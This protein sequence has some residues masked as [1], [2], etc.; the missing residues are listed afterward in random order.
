MTTVSTGSLTLTDLNDSKQLILYLNGNYK[1]QIY[2]PN[3]TTYVPS[4]SSSNLVITPEL[5]IAGGNGTN[6]LPTSAVKSVTWY[7]G[8]QT[9]TALT[10]TT[11]GTTGGGLSYSIPTGAVATTAKPLTIKS[12][13]T[14]VNSQIFTCQVIYT[15]PATTFDITCKAQFEITKITNGQKGDAGIN[16]ITA[17]LSN[18]ADTVPADSSGGSQVIT[19]VSATIT[20]YEGATDVTSSWSMG[21]PVVTGLGALNTAYTLTGTPANRTFTLT[22]TNPMTADIAT[23]TWTLTRSGYASII[24][25]FTISRLKNG[26]AGTSPTLYRLVPS[27]NA[28]QRS[29]TNVFNPTSISFTSKSQ[30]GTGAYG[31]YNARWVIEDTTDNSTWTARTVNPTTDEATKSYTPSSTS[32]K[33]VRAKIYLAGG[34]TTLLD[35]QL[36]P[37]VFDGATGIDSLYLNVWAPNGDTMRNGSTNLD[38]Q[39]DLY[40]GAGLVTPTATKWYIQDGTAT[41]ASGGDAD[42]GNGWRLIN[43]VA[44]PTTAP[45]LALQANTGTKLTATTYYVKYTWCGLS[46]ETIG[47][48]EASLAV[49]ANNDLKVTIPAF[50]TNVASA[51][52]YIGTATGVLKYAGTISTSAGNLVITKFDSSAEAIPTATTA[53]IS[54]TAQTITVRPWS[55]A[56]L[57][58]FKCV[59][60][61]SSVKYTG[62]T[63]IKDMQD[64]IQVNILGANIFKNGQG[65]VTLTAQMLQ[66]G[67]PISNSGYT[68]TWSLYQ[69][70]GTLIKTYANTTD[71][72]TVPATDVNGTA[73]ILCDANK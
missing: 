38:V 51:R 21:T 52:V 30:T 19:G 12:N 48:T 4:F 53:S 63:A 11:T 25:K 8:T 62:V 5:Y 72:V 35:E 69:T 3:G 70:N 54:S 17:I 31:N 65:S 6:M 16:A 49:T 66:A 28:I 7:E 34:T 58:G 57:E 45:T 56:G 32:I 27:A 41:T 43:T 42:G 9:T 13:L 71:T 33:A 14:S 61:Y 20:V 44:N 15:D 55:V 39:A 18:E 23:V 68:F 36:I 29:V 24:K 64:P 46:G 26:V 59:A 47:S 2:D 10:E 40:K 1:T 22:G 37:V 67:V 60:T 73:Y 50:G